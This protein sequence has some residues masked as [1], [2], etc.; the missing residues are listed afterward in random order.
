MKLFK[1]AI[2][3]TIIVGLGDEYI[4][5]FVPARIFYPIDIAF[6]AFATV[7]AI[8][9]SSAPKWSEKQDRK[10]IE[11]REKTKLLNRSTRLSFLKI[12]YLYR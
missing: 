7:C 11:I 3:L 6:N 9:A 10:F 4:Q 1:N 8:E 2:G 5:W 12:S